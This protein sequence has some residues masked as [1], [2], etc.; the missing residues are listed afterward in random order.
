MRGG[1][2]VG[3]NR[4]WVGGEEQRVEGGDYAKEAGE[5]GA[6]VTVSCIDHCPCSSRQRYTSMDGSTDK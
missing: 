2:V 6:G 4:G 1:G 5:E 3:R